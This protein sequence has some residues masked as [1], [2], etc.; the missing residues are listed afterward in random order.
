MRKKKRTYYHGTTA[1]HLKTILKQGLQPVEGMK[2]I[3]YDSYP[4]LV[5]MWDVIK[6]NL[7]GHDEDEDDEFEPDLSIGR[8]FDLA[9][10]SATAAFISSDSNRLLVLKID[11]PDEYVFPDDSS[12]G[13][14]QM[15]AVSTWV[16][17]RKY[18]I[19]YSISEDVGL[20]KPFILRHFAS[21]E[22]ISLDLTPMQ[23]HAIK[24]T[25]NSYGAENFSIF[26]Y[27][28]EWEH[29]IIER[30]KRK[31]PTHESSSD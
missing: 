22:K 17:P 14:A 31:L 7:D 5:Y 24:M 3:W 12:D 16:V 6:V 27:Q 4:N 18:I 11:M 2:R 28:I 1:E 9:T 13:M 25:D 29:H 15:G 21:N 8:A 23:R 20:F 10:D 30:R 26:D 19:S